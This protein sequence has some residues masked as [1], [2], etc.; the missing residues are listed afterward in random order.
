M[1][2]PAATMRPSASRDFMPYDQPRLSMQTEQT[3]KLS[4][5]TTRVINITCT[6]ATPALPL[7][8]RITVAP[9]GRGYEQGAFV[10]NLAPSVNSKKS[11]KT[12]AG[13]GAGKVG[14]SQKVR[15]GA[16]ITSGPKAKC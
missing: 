2:E 5:D 4:T 13:Y 14:S 7:N 9:Q 10:T 6:G 11:E 16:E 3:P 1:A 12:T 15:D 8:G